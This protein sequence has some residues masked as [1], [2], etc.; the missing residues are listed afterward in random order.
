LTPIDGGFE[1]SIVVDG[2]D[3]VPVALEFWFRPGGELIVGEGGELV[4]ANGTT[5]LAGGSAKYR[6]DN[7]SSRG[8]TIGPGRSDHRWANLRGAEPP[9]DGAV[10]LTIAGFTPFRQRLRLV[11]TA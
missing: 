1:L 10:P 5:F 7:S 4:A 9:I 2:T 8:W 11:A 6:L 3:R